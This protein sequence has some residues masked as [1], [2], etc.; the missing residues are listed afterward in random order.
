[1]TIDDEQPGLDIAG[2]RAMQTR[3][4]V[5][6]AQTL[7]GMV[8]AMVAD[9]HLHDREIQFL[10]TWLAQNELVARTWPGC[11][12]AAQVHHVLSDG[13]I[14][15]DERQHLMAVLAELSSNDFANTGSAMP[16]PT[17]LPV[18][19]T[20]ALNMLHAGVVHTGTFLYGTRAACERL[21]LAMGAMPLDNVTRSTDVLVIGA[22]VTPS[23]ITESY[24][25][26]ILRGVEL[27]AGGHPI[28][29]VS[30]RRWFEHATLLGKA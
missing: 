12:I 20:S 25:R 21:S 6:A 16:E 2:R 10:S 13:V 15:D 3:I 7:M 14:T 24:G 17:K 18:D 27:R 8:T 1:M 30:E 19:D 11:T 29:I 5:K 28:C 4:E 26:K 22:R 23:W 9:E